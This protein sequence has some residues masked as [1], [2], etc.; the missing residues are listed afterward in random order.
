MQRDGSMVAG[1]ARRSLDEQCFHIL[2]VLLG[3]FTHRGSSHA[4][5]P[6]GVLAA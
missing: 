5:L 2:K 3:D 1:H 4:A 6:G